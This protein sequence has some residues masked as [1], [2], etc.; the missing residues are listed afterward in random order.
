MGSNDK[1]IYEVRLDNMIDYSLFQGNAVIGFENFGKQK[2]I[3]HAAGLSILN[4]KKEI[5]KPLRF[6]ISKGGT[7]VLNKGNKNIKKQG[8]ETID[9]ALNFN[10]KAEDIFF[11]K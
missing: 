7:R 6:L 1:G 4:H 9:F 8:V 10:I 2:L 11:M 3:L 5:I